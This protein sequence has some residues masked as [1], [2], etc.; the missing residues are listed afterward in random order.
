MRKTPA[1]TVPEK[2]PLRN[3]CVM[4]AVSIAAF[5][6]A[7]SVRC[8][9]F[10]EIINIA[11]QIT[12]TADADA[13]VLASNKCLHQWIGDA[14][15]AWLESHLGQNAN[16]QSQ[17]YVSLDYIRV[18]RRQ[19]HIGSQSFCLERLVDLRAAGES[20]IVSNDR[21]LSDSFQRQ[22]L[23]FKQRMPRR[24]ND[25][26]IPL[27]AWQH[28]QFLKQLDRLGGDCDVRLPRGDQFRYLGR[29]PCRKIYFYLDTMRE[30]LIAR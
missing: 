12:I 28:Y 30:C 22:F 3:R 4:N 14:C 20:K 21:I 17:F 7:W 2:P 8:E 16:A 19:H 26:T 27:V 1:A 24:D 5:I 15:H 29:L 10:Y 18:Y 25:A 11:S 9:G 13:S 23:E 6:A